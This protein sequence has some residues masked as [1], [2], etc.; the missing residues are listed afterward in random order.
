M[1]WIWL[2]ANDFFIKLY[3]YY[4]IVCDRSVYLLN[5]WNLKILFLHFQ[6]IPLDITSEVQKEIMSELE[7][8]YKVGK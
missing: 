1:F 6:V 4:I 3:L 2:L 8:L 7:I 5:V